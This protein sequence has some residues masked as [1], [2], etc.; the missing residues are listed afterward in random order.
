M[1]K[2]YSNYK[3][4]KIFYNNNIKL[5]KLKFKIYNSNYKIVNKDHNKH[6]YYKIN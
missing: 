6:N 2:L 1:H 5:N 4:K 3:L